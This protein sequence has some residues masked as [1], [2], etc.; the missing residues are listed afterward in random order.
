MAHPPAT[1]LIGFGGPD[2]E[3]PGSRDGRLMPFQVT[4]G[5]GVDTGSRP[6]DDGEVIGA[7]RRR[8]G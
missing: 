1:S 7:A 4:I 8:L 5:N 6:V 3:G 2:G